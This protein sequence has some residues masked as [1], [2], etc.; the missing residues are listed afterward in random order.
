MTKEVLESLQ[1]AQEQSATQIP[2]PEGGDAGERVQEPVGEDRPVPEISREDRGGESAPEP[3]AS[4]RTH[5]ET[6]VA[7]ARELEREFPEFDL[8]SALKDPDFVRLTAPGVGLDPRR[9]WL[10][11]HPEILAGR[12]VE[13]ARALLASSLRSGAERPREGGNPS[14]AV[15]AADY[16][17]LSRSEQLRLKER[18]LQASARGEKLYP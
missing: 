6:L 17:N 11:L 16:R 12:A 5:Y 13:E 4:V 9:A 2:E 1:D 15:I 3:C 8:G 14:P 10:A 7:S 18:I